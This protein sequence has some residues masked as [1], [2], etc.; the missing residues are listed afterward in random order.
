MT[1]G[2]KIQL[3][4]VLPPSLR[5]K[6]I[7]YRQKKN[8]TTFTFNR[9][10]FVLQRDDQFVEEHSNFTCTVCT[11]TQGLCYT[12]LLV[13]STTTKEPQGIGCAIALRV[14]VVL[15]DFSFKNILLVSPDAHI[16]GL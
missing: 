8:M 7:L 14:V 16:K 15:K 12:V 10:H 11:H 13:L 2:Q 9:L 5:R 3:Y 4:A 6:Q 1:F